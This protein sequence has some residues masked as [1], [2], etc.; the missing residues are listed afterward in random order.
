MKECI[1]CLTLS[2]NIE[3]PPRYDVLNPNF[4]PNTQDMSTVGP[5]CE[6]CFEA[7]V[8]GIHIATTTPPPLEEI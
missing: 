7:T 5:Y 4:D 6:D 3:E 8:T 1:S 2:V